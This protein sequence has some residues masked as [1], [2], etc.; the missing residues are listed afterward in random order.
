MSR[1]TP[2]YRP[3]LLL[4]LLLLLLAACSELDGAPTA[5][6]SG[7]SDALAPVGT[8]GVSESYSGPYL[9]DAAGAVTDAA[10][11]RVVS[12]APGGSFFVQVNYE[13]TS[14]VTGIDVNLVNA[15]PEG[16]AGTLDP[17]Q[18]FFTLG[19]P[20]GIS[21][22][23]GCDLSDSPKEVSCIYEVRVAEDAVNVTKLEG[24]EGEFAYVFQTKV[25][26]AAG[27]TSEEMERGYVVVTG[28]EGETPTPKPEPEVCTDPVNV[29]DEVLRIEI[30]NTLGLGQDEDITCEGLAGLTRFIYDPEFPDGVEREESSIATLEGLQFAVNLEQLIIVADI[31]NYDAVASLTRLEDLT[32]FDIA[33]PDFSLE[34]LRNLTTLTDLSISGPEG[35]AAQD[36]DALASLVNLRDLSISRV[37][38]DDL[39]VLQNLTELTELSLNSNNIADLTP[40]QNLTK[41]TVLDL[42]ANNVA[43]LTPLQSLPRLS[44]LNLIGNQVTDISPLVE[45]EGL[46]IPLTFVDLYF[47]PIETCPGTKGRADIDTLI[48]RGVSVLFDRPE[49]CDNSGDGGQE[50]CTNPVNVPDNTLR[51]GLRDALGLPENADITCASLANLTIFNPLVPLEFVESLE[52]LQ[53]AVNLKSATIPATLPPEAL[54]PLK[55]LTSLQQLSVNVLITGEDSLSFLE[56]LVNLEFLSISS[57]ETPEYDESQPEVDIN[58]LR[59]LTKLTSLTLNYLN[60]SDI[61]LLQNLTRLNALSLDGNKISDISPLQ[62]LTSLVTLYLIRNDIS[63]LSALQNLPDLRLLN[64]FG[65]NISDI[66]PLVANEGLAEG[67]EVNLG[68]NPLSDQAFD[69]I[70]TL[71]ERGVSI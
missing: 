69:D 70:E 64:L 10:D 48:L 68:D 65:N 2:R 13:D 21:E 20:T 66:G 35:A 12:V 46:D 34:P 53:Y 27:N 32:L 4:S 56:N 17:T 3:L 49:N 25:T 63:D 44:G 36:Q 31:G 39:T 59:D 57:V 6:G 62:N 42:G 30:R 45:G 28:D 15:S 47:N 50:N 19:E 26:D 38:L 60:I 71:E 22:P 5:P 43:D 58:P 51:E 54:A 7:G 14:G 61:G 33:A 18:S 1:Y 11:E 23:S 37:G 67:D 8:F 16:L 55:D 52:G 29:P 9:S 24:A 41:I 40:L